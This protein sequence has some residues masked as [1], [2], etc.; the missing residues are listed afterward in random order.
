MIKVLIADDQELMRESLKI[1][2]SSKSDIEIVATCGDGNEVLDTIGKVDV[3]VILMDIRMP[4]MDGIVCTKKI[5]EKYPN[6]GIIVLTTFDDD[7]YIFEA[8]KNG[9]SGY[10]LKGISLDE[11]YH[12]IV[13]VAQGGG[14]IHPNIVNKTIK[15]FS[16]MAHGQNMTE[17][18]EKSD[19]PP[20][21]KTEK[22]IIQK[23]KQGLSNKEIAKELCFSEGTI[24][25]YI[26][27]ILDK[28]YLRDRTQL[29]VWATENQY[30]I[31]D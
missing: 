7:E 19:L 26:S 6:V 28:L 15:M 12:G 8:L 13:S 24:R 27:V 2:L 4:G 11:L 21:S 25:N 23:V 30:A 16:T 9:A 17:N 29:A 22:K 18:K 3:D 5:K 14:I 31:Q 1:L 10:L 20:L